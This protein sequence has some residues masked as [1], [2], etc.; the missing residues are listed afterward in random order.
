[1]A[2]QERGPSRVIGSGCLAEKAGKRQ[3]GASTNNLSKIH[4]PSDARNRPGLFPH[5]KRQSL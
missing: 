2:L 1:M 5:K 4:L 3:H